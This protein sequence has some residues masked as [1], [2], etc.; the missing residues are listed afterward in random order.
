LL[1]LVAVHS[2]HRHAKPSCI[3]GP[4]PGGRSSLTAWAG[5]PEARLCRNRPVGRSPGQM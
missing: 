1:G 3:S 2:H 4:G 5:F